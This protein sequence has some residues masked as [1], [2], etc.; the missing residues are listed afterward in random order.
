M[1]ALTLRQP[2]ASLVVA[3]RKRYETRSWRTPFRGLVAIHASKGFTT[4]YQEL[5]D[6][7][8]R[9]GLLDCPL[10]TGAIIGVARIASCEPTENVRARL[11]ALEREVGDYGPGRFAWRLEGVRSLQ[12]PIPCRGALSLWTVPPAVAREIEWQLGSLIDTT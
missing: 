6:D 2:W 12:D 4:E 5:A 7:F 8:G 1:K 11:G 10:P 9:R 3:G